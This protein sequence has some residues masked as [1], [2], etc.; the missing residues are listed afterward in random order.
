MFGSIL[1]QLLEIRLRLK[2]P[3]VIEFM[4]AFQGYHKAD[5]ESAL[6]AALIWAIGQLTF[7]EIVIVVDGVD[8][9]PNRLEICK[10][11]CQ[12]SN[13]KIKVLV[14]SRNERDIAAVFGSQK[15]VQF[16]VDI[17]RLDIATHV[18]WAFENDEK[19]KNLR[20]EF[21][22]EMK[23]IILSKSDGT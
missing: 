22:N 8:E 14:I 23:E 20:P 17:S 12:M 6:S 16:T 13:D 11:L 1:R 19:L 18:D 7:H 21:K 10:K 2:V 3:Q 15:H 4:E 9:C 5:G